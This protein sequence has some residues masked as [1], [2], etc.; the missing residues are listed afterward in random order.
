ML[1]IISITSAVFVL[2]A[3]NE[4]PSGPPLQADSSPN[5]LAVP[6]QSSGTAASFSVHLLGETDAGAVNSEPAKACQQDGWQLLVRTDGSSFRNT[7]DCVSYRA[8]GG[9]F[10]SVGNNRCRTLVDGSF[11]FRIEGTANS[12]GSGTFFESNNGSC[13]G[14][15]AVGTYIVAENSTDA[16]SLCFD[17]TFALNPSGWSPGVVIVGSIGTNEWACGDS[18]YL[19]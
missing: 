19:P 1:R 7:G 12:P 10:G 9:E 17:A 3:C 18:R 14:N 4:L 16:V 15:E 8:R 5:H 11:D 2:A 6:T 13:T